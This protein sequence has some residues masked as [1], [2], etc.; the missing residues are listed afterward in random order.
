MTKMME[1]VRSRRATLRRDRAIHRVMRD[2]PSTSMRREVL[3]IVSRFEMS[4][5]TR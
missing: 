2:A 5:L 4:S 1:R 3:E